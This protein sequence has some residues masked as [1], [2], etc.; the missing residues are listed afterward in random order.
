[1]A[2][3][4]NKGADQPAHQRCL[5]SAFVVRCLD[6]TIPKFAIS[7]IRRTALAS[8]DEQ[9]DLSLICLETTEDRFSR[10]MAQL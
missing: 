4:T 2:H 1:M 10:G 7:V 5:I 6:G 3:A 8:E 9:A